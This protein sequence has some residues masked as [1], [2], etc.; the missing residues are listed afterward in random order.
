MQ[1]TGTANSAL[2]IGSSWPPVRCQGL[3]ETA[4]QRTAQYPTV[5]GP[6]VARAGLRDAPNTDRACLALLMREPVADPALDE[7][8]RM[9]LAEC[10]AGAGLP[11]G[12]TLDLW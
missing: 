1:F 8:R 11:A 2:F 6:L 4:P 10:S 12:L 3:T 5:S 7:L 9:A